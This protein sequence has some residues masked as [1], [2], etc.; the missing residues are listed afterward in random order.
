MNQTENKKK[1]LEKI[2]KNYYPGYLIPKKQE[3]KLF[4]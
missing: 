1:E 4:N 3:E 2:I